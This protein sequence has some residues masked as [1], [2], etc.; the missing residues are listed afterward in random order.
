MRKALL[1]IINLFVALTMVGVMGR[2]AFFLVHYSLIK[3]G[4]E[5]S[6]M[7]M[8]WHGLRLDM[9]VA[10]YFSFVPVVLM[11]VKTWVES[12]V[13]RM[14]ERCYYA[15]IALA[16]ALALTANIALYGYWGFPLDST[17]LFYLIT[18][19]A[20]AA[21]SATPLMMIGAI[22]AVALIAIGIYLLLQRY[23]RVGE[24]MPIKKALLTTGML[25][26]CGGLL[27]IP[28]RGGFTVAVN[29]VGSVYFSDNIRLNHATVNP[30]FSFLESVSHDEDFASKY[31]FLD[32]KEADK[33]FGKLTYT[34]MRSDSTATLLPLSQEF[35][36][37]VD[38]EKGG[39]KVV[40]VILESFSKYIMTEGGHVKGVTPVMDALTDEGIYFTNFHANSFRTDRGL[41]AIL[42]GFPAQPTM[43]LMKYPRK[44]NE[45]YAIS[46][47]LKNA[48]YATQYVYGGDA[49]FTNMRSYLMA[50]GFDDVI[51]EEDYD[52][53]LRTSKW[54][55]NDSVLFARA[56]QEMN[57]DKKDARSFRVIQTSSSHEPFEVPHHALE[58]VRL[59][60]FHYTDQCLGQ[61][62]DALRQRDD[63]Q[64]TL[65]VVVPDHLGCYPEDID[66]FKMYR[67][68]IPLI[69][70]GGAVS[71]PKRIGTIGSQQD[72]A[73][74]LL[75]I[76][77]I[78]H[79]EF[80]Y[81]KDMLDTHSPHFAFFAVPDAMG[82]VTEENTMIFDNTSGKT[83]LDIGKKGAN[84]R[85]MQA[86]LQ[87][88]Y[89][90]IAK[91]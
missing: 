44:T 46:R 65:V 16:L 23:A 6:F 36:D 5:T 61:F 21:A 25:L 33:L 13:L 12:K 69:F 82:M 38:G 79:S 4:G 85:S 67:Y 78:D 39:V 28:A 54:G 87:T 8:V 47:S 57:A 83:V 20:D 41:M 2:I 80:T 72:I 63:W 24:K 34:K 89:D 9:A 43:S 18:S 31:R 56:L 50:T 68:Q 11:I 90:D 74:T 66:N 88:I 53:S 42:S 22:V 29:N 51:S 76:L 59:N 14:V 40:M 70:T 58:N 91:R 81:S 10:S 75:A 49:N 52:N 64:R 3:T 32:D 27:V 26:L 45:I 35:L 17:P 73:A 84:L 71:Q 48:G 1:T 7:P 55:V 30:V 77:G 19:P 60:A 37:A 62:L 86:Y 15:V